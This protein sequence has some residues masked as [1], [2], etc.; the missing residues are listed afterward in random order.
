MS[1]MVVCFSY[2]NCMSQLAVCLQYLLASMLS[3]IFVGKMMM[4]KG[5]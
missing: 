4:M 5:S 3:A 1:Q 2:N